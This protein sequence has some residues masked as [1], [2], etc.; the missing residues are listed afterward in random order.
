MSSEQQ[1]EANRL[2]AQKSSGPRTPEGKKRISSN[3]LKHGLT[4]KE[5]LMPYEKLEDFESFSSD[6][7]F[8][9]RPKGGLE[10]ISG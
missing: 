2:N 3:A 4:G 5:I 1:I 8:S 7:Y 9:L 6:I 10:E